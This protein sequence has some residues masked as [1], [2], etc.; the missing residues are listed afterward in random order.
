ME[1]ETYH[2]DFYHISQN[3]KILMLGYLFCWS[4]MV[5]SQDSRV[6]Y[7]RVFVRGFS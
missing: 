7:C 2:F 6:G 3:V 1:M 5:E 4:S